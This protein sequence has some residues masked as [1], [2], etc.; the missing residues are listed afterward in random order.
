MRRKKYFQQ[1]VIGDDRGIELNLDDFDMTR[2]AMTNIFVGRMVTMATA[3]AGLNGVNTPQGK[4]NSL[5]APETRP[6]QIPP[7]SYG[8]RT[9]AVDPNCQPD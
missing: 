5:C 1:A 3:V 4:E 9:A 6:R 2:V 7:H 8:K